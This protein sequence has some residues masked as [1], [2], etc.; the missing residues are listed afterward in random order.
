MRPIPGYPDHLAG[1]DGTIYSTRYKGKPPKRGT[2][3][4]QLRALKARLS[5]DG[6]LVVAIIGSLRARPRYTR[7]HRLV[8]MAFHGPPPTPQHEAQHRDGSRTNNRPEN[9]KWGLPKENAEDR[10]H[11][12]RTARGERAGHAR[13]TAEQVEQIRE[14]V[15]RGE[16]H[17][18]VA[19]SYGLHK[20]SISHIVTRR[21]WR[22]A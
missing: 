21:S 16:L 18:V 3:G 19:A 22:H 6:Y 7:A 15:A 12:G 13:L 14:R 5:H 1:E 10:E 8:C 2:P 17:R 20:A 9:L 4:A 11:H